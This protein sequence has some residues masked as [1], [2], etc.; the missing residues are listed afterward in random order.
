M[1]TLYDTDLYA[2]SQ[3]QAHLLRTLQPAGLDWEHLAEEIDDVGSSV[4][5]AVESHLQRIVEHLL[6]L[7]YAPA[8]LVTDNRRGWQRSIAA[9]RPQL[10]KKVRKNPSLECKLEELLADAYG[11]ARLDVL[12]RLPELEEEA[13]P[14][15]CPWTLDE[16]RREGFYPV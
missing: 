2:W 10:A 11:T 7:A 15:T 13:L 8:Y 6:K 5:A 9:Q 3:E 14:E 12:T 1:N 4:E 16:V